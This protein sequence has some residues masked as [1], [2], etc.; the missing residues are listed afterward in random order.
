MIGR[1]LTSHTQHV[2][3]LLAEDVRNLVDGMG[4][5]NQEQERGASIALAL[6]GIAEGWYVTPLPEHNMAREMYFAALDRVPQ[7]D[8]GG[9]AQHKEVA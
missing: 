8:D 4:G 6:E 5:D 1:H 3:R 9:E 7:D 2:L